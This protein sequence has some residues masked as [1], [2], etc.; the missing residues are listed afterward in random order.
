MPQADLTSFHSLTFYTLLL[1][2]FFF[3]FSYFYLTPFWSTML[4]VSVKKTLTSL[5]LFVT[6]KNKI[7][8][9]FSNIKFIKT[10]RSNNFLL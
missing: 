10:N 6:T 9:L 8:N 7:V 4:K 2:V 1:I 3:N 5:F